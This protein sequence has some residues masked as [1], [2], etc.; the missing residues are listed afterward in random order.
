MAR[1]Y[2]P[3][4]CDYVIEDGRV[5]SL[6]EYKGRISGTMMAGILGISP[7]STP[8]QIACNLLGLCSED[9][10][11][12]PA[13]KMGQALEGRIIEYLDGAYPGEGVF[14]PAEQI[15]EKR[16]GDH[17]SWVSDFED[18]Y[19]AG[20]VDGLVMTEDGVNYILEIKTS[21]NLDSWKEGVPEY[22]YWQVALYNEFITQQDKAY[23]GLGIV[24]Q[25]DYGHPKDWHP[26][27]DTVVMFKIDIDR[28][29]VQARMNDIRYW[30]DTFIKEGVTPCYDPDN[31]GDVEMFNHLANLA[32][33]PESISEMIDQYFKLDAIVKESER[34]V[35]D[36]AQM[37]DDLKNKIKAYMDAHKMNELVSASGSCK[38]GITTTPTIS[39][40]REKMIADGID[41]TPYEIVS[42]TKRF[43]VKKCKKGE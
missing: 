29:E 34:S 41:V 31:P 18:D 30:Y 36:K 40:D 10:G 22:Y 11:N 14:V 1:V 2:N 23:V 17:D 8:F 24:E 12:K 37:R 9:I 21:A 15:Y 5:R 25:E 33:D 28:E 13:V 35:K 38:A 26:N 32:S 16:E 3:P 27:E 7:W 19:F 20:H 42:V 43:T 4:K 6:G 39:L